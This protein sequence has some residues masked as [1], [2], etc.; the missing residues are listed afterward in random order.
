MNKKV[1][2]PLIRSLLLLALLI[3]LSGIFSEVQAAT[4]KAKKIAWSNVESKMYMPVKS[5]KKLKVKITPKKAQK[6]KL[7]WS[8]SNNKI[9]SVSKSGKVYAK[10]TG[11]VMI[12]CKISS[13]PRKKVKCKIYVVKPAKKISVDKSNVVLQIGDIYKRN[14]SVLPKNATVKDV[15]FS[16]SSPKIASVDKQGNV[17]GKAE[18]TAAIKISS[19]DGLAKTASYK[20][21]VIGKLKDSTHFIAHRGLS[22]QAPENTIKAFQLAG[23]SGFWGAETDVRKT[24]DGHFILMHDDTLK[25]MCGINRT[26]GD[27]TLGEI[28]AS[29]VVGGSNYEKYKLDKNATTIPTLEEYLQACLKYHMVPVVEIK[30]SFNWESKESKAPSEK[31]D[32]HENASDTEKQ[33][34]SEDT[35]E[36]SESEKSPEPQEIPD[37]KDISKVSDSSEDEELP[38]TEGDPME[39]I[40]EDLPTITV[41]AYNMQLQSVAEDDLRN[42]YNISQ[43]IMKGSKIV[44]IAFD[45]K[46]LIKLR[47]II[48]EE[49]G[50]NIELQHLVSRPD[51][52]MIEIYKEKQIHLDSYFGNLDIATA[53]KFMNSGIN[54]NVWTV[55]NP[56]T[57]WEYAKNKVP[58]ITTNCKFW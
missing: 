19:K 1:K 39:K 26:P 4:P 7:K 21:Q 44:F 6:R 27:M 11:T 57:V 23:E 36:L 50:Q 17:T 37:D 8:S 56:V 38:V 42:L 33:V 53:K 18:G 24:K 9:A 30:M 46:T 47:S 22:S 43:S 31:K 13:Q 55:D 12:T 28:K 49:N 14:A 5:S 41:D 10:K 35:S 34:K 40:I 54:V 48:D 29:S 16:S 51:M 20:V 45:L 32:A 3:F 25:R 15:K 58:Y 52:N 2:Y